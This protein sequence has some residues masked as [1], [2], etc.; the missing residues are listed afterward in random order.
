MKSLYLKKKTNSIIHYLNFLK[1]VRIN[2]F[3]I[4]QNGDEYNIRQSF[5]ANSRKYGVSK[6]YAIKKIKGAIKRYPQAPITG[7]DENGKAIATL[8][9]DRK[10]TF[11]KYS[12]RRKKCK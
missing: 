2:N 1:G 7:I 5:A 3:I 4:R 11:V 10:D 8:E 9:Y 6:F 12:L